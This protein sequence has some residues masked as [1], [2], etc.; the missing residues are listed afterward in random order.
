[1]PVGVK[2]PHGKKTIELRIRFF[3][4]QLSSVPGNIWPK[5]AWD[6][7]SIYTVVNDYH[8]IEVAGAT[9]NSTAEI[10]LAIE[11]VLVKA[12]IRLHPTGRAGAIY[13]P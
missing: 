12:G 1:M 10:T 4:D 7:G 5:H 9:F 11:K 13:S 8:D 3:T 6:R 2:A